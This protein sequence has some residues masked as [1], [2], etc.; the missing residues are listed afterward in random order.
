MPETLTIPQTREGAQALHDRLVAMGNVAVGF[1]ENQC[2]SEGLAAVD[3]VLTRLDEEDMASRNGQMQAVATD[4]I[5]DAVKK[6]STLK[7]E[8]C[9]IASRVEALS[10]FA[11]ALD[12]V[13]GGVKSI[14]AM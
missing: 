12:S 9:S 11:G 7:D 3:V 14:F 6:L 5:K 1:D 8:L 13:L 10:D 4:D 2:V